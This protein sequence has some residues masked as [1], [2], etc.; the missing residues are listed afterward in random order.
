[1]EYEVIVVGGGVGGLTTAALLAARGLSV[2][3]F[4]RQSQVGGC[5]ADF[6][7]LGYKFE[8]TLGLYSGWETGG[9]WE[10]IWNELPGA[11][12]AVTKLSPGY[13]VRLPDGRDVAVGD[14]RE[15][16]ESEL[17]RAFPVYA[18]AAIEFF[19]ALDRIARS[20]SDEPAERFLGDAPPDFRLFV[21][22]QL[23]AFGQCTSAQCSAARAA[24]LLVPTRQPMWSIEGSGSELANSLTQSLKTSGGSL[25][26]NSPVL[27]LA[28]D[29]G[30]VPVGIDLL[31]GERV[32]ARRA[33]I[34]NLTVWDTYGKLVGP[35]RTP[36]EITAALR[37]LHAWGAHLLFLGM[38]EGAQDQL[39]SSRILIAPQGD[40]EHNP[41]QQFGINLSDAA[42]GRAPNGKCAVT[43]STFTEADEWFS[44]HEDE[45]S[46]EAQDQSALETAW[47]RLHQAV[48]EFG[49]SVEVIETA[50][51]RTFYETTRRKFGM[52]GSP[53]ASA[54]GSAS[55]ES[56][57]RTHLPKLFL[58]GDTVS[59]GFGLESIAHNSR[60][61]ADLL[62]SS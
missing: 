23:Q 51:P 34:S 27:R 57:A 47:A 19:R 54:R 62:T 41:E 9:T 15:G 61:L 16:L 5:V 26:L 14:D 25:R 6:E 13:V 60:L 39:P 52:I 53:L 11:A 59:S 21:D 50:T 10:R 8:P 43:V 7:H 28:Y 44:F 46:L 32:L 56:F 3:L 58:V 17:V 12:P 24:R 2:C 1:M 33:I 37:N 49:D 30:G 40:G 20:G 38:D 42:P 36:K 18:K 55:V 22:T 29:A 45:T 4:E 48:P 31:S 35:G